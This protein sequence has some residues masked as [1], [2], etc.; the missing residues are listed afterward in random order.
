MFTCSDGLFSFDIHVFPSPSLI[1]KDMMQYF[2]LKN[3]DQTLLHQLLT[4]QN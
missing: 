3:Q 4:P 2:S 1:G